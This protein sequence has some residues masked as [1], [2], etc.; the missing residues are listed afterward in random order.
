MQP[1]KREFIQNNSVVLWISRVMAIVASATV[2]LMA[3]I[4]IIDVCGRFFFDSPLKGTFELVGILLVIAGS[5]ALGYCQLLKMNIRISI[6]TERFPLRVRIVLD[7]IAYL[8]GIAVVGLICWQGALRTHEYILK[9]LGAVTSTLSLPFWPF[10]LLMVV[11]IGWVGV[12][13]IIDLINSIAEL[14]K[15]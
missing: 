1:T 12:I 13:F 7:I 10:I 2:G 11:G 4:T 14:L 15:R 9:D 8:I 3:L 6:L 5:W